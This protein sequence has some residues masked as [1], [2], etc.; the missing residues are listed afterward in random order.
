MKKKIK[1]QLFHEIINRKIIRKI[2]SPIAIIGT[3]D[4]GRDPVGRLKML[5]FDLRRK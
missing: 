1:D 2:K 4:R 3:K 5:Y